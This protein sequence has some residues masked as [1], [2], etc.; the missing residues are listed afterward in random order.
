MRKNYIFLLTAASVLLLSGCLKEEELDG[1]KPLDLEPMTFFAEMESGADTKTMIEGNVGDAVRY[2]KW[3]P[4]DKIGVY[5][6]E[7]NK[8][9]TF[10]NVNEEAS[11]TAVFEG[12]NSVQDVYYAVYPYSESHSYAK[13]DMIMTVDLPAVTRLLGKT[14]Q[15]L[16]FFSRGVER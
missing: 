7:S 3:L 9:E 12:V 4:E 8:F 15:T 13:R 10:V 1:N 2:L 6:A 11:S 5:N 14:A 16:R